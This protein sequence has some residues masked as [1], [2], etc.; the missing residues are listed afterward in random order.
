MKKNILW[1]V[2][3]CIV[4][5][6]CAGVCYVVNHLFGLNWFDDWREYV[7]IGFAGAIAS[8]FGPILAAWVEKVFK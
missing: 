3:F 8:I 4:W 6:L 5:S 1:F 2:A 7:V